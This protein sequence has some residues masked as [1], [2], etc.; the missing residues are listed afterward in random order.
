MLS[1]IPILL[2]VPSVLILILLLFFIIIIIRNRSATKGLAIP[3][4]NS[5]GKKETRIEE[6]PK[7]EKE[8]E[9]KK[10]TTISPSEKTQTKEEVDYYSQI[11]DLENRLDT[12]DVKTA[13]K[14]LIKIIRKFFADY[15]NLNYEFTYEELEKELKE[16]DKKIS[17]SSDTLSKIEYSPHPISKDVLTEMIG[18]FK[19]IIKKTKPQPEI[20]LSLNK[21]FRKIEKLLIK[22]QKIPKKNP[23]KAI[24]VYK[25]IYYL[26]YKLPRSGKLALHDSII[27][28][29]KSI[30]STLP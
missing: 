13:Y 27:E 11:K 15:L 8:V 20:N 23:N 3:T 21:D 12:M 6:K 28:F 1:D 7:E 16:K 24:R 14:E 2:I 26:Y 25:E 22:G 18:E 29:Y 30:V 19:S 5:T 9:E 10:K 4:F 17:V